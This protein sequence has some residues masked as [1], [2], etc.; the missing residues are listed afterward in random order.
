MRRPPVRLLF[1]REREGR[2]CVA[3][4]DERAGGVTSF[5]LR[6]PVVQLCLMKGPVVQLCLM[7]GPV[8]QLFLMKGPVVQQ[9]VSAPH[10]AVAFAPTLYPGV[11]VRVIYHT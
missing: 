8:V 4:S 7:K 9:H 1:V 10:M 5:F 2:W 6:G 3:L 11:W